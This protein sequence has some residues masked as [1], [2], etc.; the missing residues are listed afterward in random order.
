MKCLTC[1]SRW[2]TVP[3]WPWSRSFLTVSPWRLTVNRRTATRVCP[4]RRQK[5]K[6]SRDW[7]TPPRA[8]R[9]P[10]ER[11]RVAR[12]LAERFPEERSQEAPYQ[13]GHCQ[14]EP[15]PV[16]RSLV[17]RSP[18]GLSQEAPYQVAHFLAELF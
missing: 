11:F 5:L 6:N 16:A 7:T 4:A 1:A 12:S 14:E 18:A 8:E 13:V 9:C 17:E 10:A 3:S 15:F 2:F